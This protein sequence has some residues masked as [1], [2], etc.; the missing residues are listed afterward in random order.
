[1][2]ANI[3]AKSLSLMTENAVTFH[4]FQRVM[5]ELG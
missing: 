3:Q 1:M 4:A 2:R 5:V